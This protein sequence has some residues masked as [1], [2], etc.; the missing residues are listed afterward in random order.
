MISRRKFLT[1]TGLLASGV[2][3]GRFGE[4]LASLSSLKKETQMKITA[5]EE[6]IQSP[7]LAKTMMPEMLKQAPFLLDWG[8]DVT[9]KITDL[10]RPHVLAFGESL[11]KLID[12]S[13][14]RVAEMDEHGIDMQMLSYAG[15]PQLVQ[16]EAGVQAVRDA[17]DYL[18]E[19]VRS[20]LSR[21]GKT[22]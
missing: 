6:H 7:T 19:K 10:S 4:I 17:N 21:F 9:D 20:N 11:K 12:V 5:V 22:Q 15:L 2:V 8:K 14:E 16:G 3:L 18:I 1:Y 13:E